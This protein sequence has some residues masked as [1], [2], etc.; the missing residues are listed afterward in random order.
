MT[1]LATLGLAI[2]SKPVQDASAA[3]QDFKKDAKAAEDQATKTSQAFEKSTG[4]TIKYAKSTG[5]VWE[6]NDRIKT[7]ADE[8][9]AIQAKQALAT[10]R[11]ARALER[12]AVAARAAAA[13]LHARRI[14]DMQQGLGQ[15][16]DAGLSAGGL[17][18]LGV[19][20]AALTGGVGA[21][22]VVAGVLATELIQWGVQALIT[23]NKTKTLDEATDEHAKT[24]KELGVNYGDAGKMAEDFGKKSELALA[25]AERRARAVLQIAQATELA[26]VN[27][28]LDS[29]LSD[30]PAWLQSGN[31]NLVFEPFREAIEDL[32]N[33][34]REGNPDFQRF[35]ERI[36]QI[37]ETNPG[38]LQKWADQLFRITD[39]A[40]QAAAQLAGVNGQLGALGSGKGDRLGGAG[41]M[42][43]AQAQFDFLVDMERRMGTAFNA[44]DPNRLPKVDPADRAAERERNAYRDLIKTANDRLAQMRLEA[45]TAG[46]VGIKADALRF[47]LDLLNDAQDKGRKITPAQRAEIEKLG[48]QYEKLAEQV[49]RA[50]LATELLFE[51]DQLLRSATDQN[52]A[53]TLRGAGLP[54][55]FDS[56][57][58]ALIRTNERLREVRDLAQ[59]FFADFASG[60]ERGESLWDSFA[61]AG[62]NA[63][64]R[65]ADKLIEMAT[66]ELIAG[67][68][69]S[70]LGGGVG[71]FNPTAGG[72]ADMLGF[73]D[74]GYTGGR[75]GKAAGIV[76]GEE[77][78]VNADATRRNRPALEAMNNNQPMG[79]MMGGIVSA[80]QYHIDARGAQRGVG[81]EIAM[82]LE[83]YDRGSVQRLARDFPQ[84]RK[85]TG[86]V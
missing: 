45:E 79:G 71:G 4:V 49:S 29:R 51:R 25:A 9:T 15:V 75:R 14:A 73:A 35:Q 68:L 32:Q 34:I 43:A 24:V 84:L 58:A 63:L 55:D 5:G 12:E 19:G 33:G 36:Q 77:F 70:L 26:N 8:L 69:G 78:V 41:A 67:L 11:A 2:D 10:D 85:R 60:L 65:I 66:D 31:V 16:V 40:A 83:R 28:Q 6:W 39:A 72:F 21:L 22:A 46:L 54:V 50:E 52:I 82:A 30:L 48:E 37:A 76:H 62:L 44:I 1:D 61:Q 3:L 7:K 42:D 80:P 74:G 59:G 86:M 27:S 20:A 53:S 57:E 17:G 64:S 56:Y 81:E 13:A 18:S 38:T 23:A 47:K